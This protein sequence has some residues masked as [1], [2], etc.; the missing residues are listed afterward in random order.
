VLGDG[1]AQSGAAS[2]AGTVGLV[3][4]LKDARQVLC[5]DAHAGVP[6]RDDHLF[7]CG[8]RADHDGAPR[9]RELARVVH[10]VGDHLPRPLDVGQYCRDPGRHLDGQIQ[11]RSLRLRP[12]L[13]DGRE[14]QVGHGRGAQAQRRLPRLDARQLQQLLDHLG[15]GI[16]LPIH[17]FEKALGGRRVLERPTAQ[18]I[19][20]GLQAGEG[21]AQLVGEV[22]HKVTPD[23]F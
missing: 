7:T 15:Q 13:L 9:R 11:P 19:H 14:E 22:G 5:R 4:A 10:Q 6:Y 20:Q 18:R 23:C 1:Q 2:A 21:R 12:K 17:A 8:L 3:E 16:H